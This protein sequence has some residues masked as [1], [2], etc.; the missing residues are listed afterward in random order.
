MAQFGQAEQ[1]RGVEHLAGQVVERL[2]VGGGG[3]LFGLAPE[4]LDVLELGA[5]DVQGL[6]LD[7]VQTALGV[8]QGLG[9]GFPAGNPDDFGQP[10]FRPTGDDGHRMDSWGSMVV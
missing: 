4:D 6:H 9:D 1:A 2:D 8:F 10:V 7:L 5:Q 3:V